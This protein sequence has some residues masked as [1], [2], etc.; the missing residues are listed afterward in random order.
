MVLGSFDNCFPDFLLS[1]LDLFS[2][3]SFEFRIPNFEFPISNG[4][5]TCSFSTKVG[6]PKLSILG[7]SE[8]Q[9]FCRGLFIRSDFDIA[10]YRSLPKFSFG[11]NI[12]YLWVCPFVQH[13]FNLQGTITT[14]F[15]AKNA[16]KLYSFLGPN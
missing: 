6:A 3:P 13:F 10:V 9:S 15:A 5:W 12:L 4:L 11:T 8:A 1:T 14:R 2:T 16:R 7:D